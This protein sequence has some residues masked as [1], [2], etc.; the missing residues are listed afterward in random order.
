MWIGWWRGGEQV[1]SGCWVCSEEQGLL[2]AGLLSRIGRK[3]GTP[4]VSLL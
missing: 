4:R 2:M 3:Q 1:E